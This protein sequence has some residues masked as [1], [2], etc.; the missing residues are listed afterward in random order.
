MK[1]FL[2]GL[3]AAIVFL[4]PQISEGALTFYTD[5]ALWEAAVGSFAD[6]VI[7]D[8]VTAGV[9]EALPFG[10][11]ITSSIN[12]EL[13]QVPTTWATW[14]GGHTPAVLWTLGATSGTGTFDSVLLTGFGL[15]ME[16]NPFSVHSMR[17]ALSDGSFLDQD[18]AGSGGAKFFGWAGG[19]ITSLTVSSDVDF[20]IGRLVIADEGE[21][22]GGGPIIPE[23]V[24]MMLFGT[25]MAGLGVVTR[26]RKI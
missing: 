20:A 15:E 7:T 10:H 1:K 2:L 8:G 22:G 21:G 13:R 4:T 3:V 14:S 17:L 5:R 18:V 16:P 19:S 24:S 25:G 6:V 12:L 23:P 26:K 9:P 11:S